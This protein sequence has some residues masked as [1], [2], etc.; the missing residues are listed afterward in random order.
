E[1][2]ILKRASPSEFTHRPVPIDMLA[3][4]IRACY[5]TTRTAEDLVRPLRT[6]PSAGALYPL[7]LYLFATRVHC[8]PKGLYHIDPDGPILTRIEPAADETVLASA[9]AQRKLFQT[10]AA[11]IFMVGVFKRSTFKYGNRGYR[12]VLIEAGHVA[13]NLNLAA[14]ALGIAARNVGG[15]RDRQ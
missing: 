13:Q 5:G 9:F 15:Y 8:L 12:F 1:K 10:A 6:A 4:V 14:T 2:I 3:G 7:E 11:T